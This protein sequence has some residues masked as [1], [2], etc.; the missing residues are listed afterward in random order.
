MGKVALKKLLLCYGYVMIL[1]YVVKYS[2]Q[3]HLGQEKRFWPVFPPKNL[4]KNTPNRHFLIQNCRVRHQ[5]YSLAMG[6]DFFGNFFFFKNWFKPVF[7]VILANKT[8]SRKCL[9]KISREN[10]PKSTISLK[11]W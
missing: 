8:R 6:V 3:G 7:W 5:G 2:K 4:S 11:F 1:C 10:Y 9:V